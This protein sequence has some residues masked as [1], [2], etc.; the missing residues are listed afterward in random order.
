MTR[1]EV[2]VLAAKQYPE[3]DT[4]SI[5]TFCLLVDVGMVYLRQLEELADD[6]PTFAFGHTPLEAVL[7]GLR[8]HL[9]E[10]TGGERS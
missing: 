1:N 3:A 6:W 7:Q 8:E 9:E 4:S 2:E 5:A 10:N